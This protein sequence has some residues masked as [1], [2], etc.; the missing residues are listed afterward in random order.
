[1]AYEMFRK[2]KTGRRRGKFITITKQGSMRFSKECYTEYMEDYSY[3]K[4][5]YSKDRNII[6][7]LLRTEE[8]VDTYKIRKQQIKNSFI[9]SAS[10]TAFLKFFNIDFS[11]TKRYSPLF[12][13]DKEKIKINLNKEI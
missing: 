13:E 8:D 12:I 4:F 3:I 1:M 6:A 9:Y 11:E 7:L 10:A 5:L 2:K